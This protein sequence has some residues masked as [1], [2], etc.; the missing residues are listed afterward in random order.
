MDIRSDISLPDGLRGMRRRMQW[1]GCWRHSGQLW[2]GLTPGWILFAA[3]ALLLIPVLYYSLDTPYA[4]VDDFAVWHAVRT[5][6]GPK[7]FYQSLVHE[8][9][10]E[11]ARY[12]PVATYYA[13]FT[14]KVYGET[15]WLHHLTRW[16]LHFGAVFVWSA[17]FLRFCPGRRSAAICLVPMGLLVW[18]WM[19]YPNSPASRLA[20]LELYTVFFLGVCVWLTALTLQ[21]EWQGK[22]GT[23]PAWWQYGLLYAA[24]L[25]L[26]SSKEIDIA[27]MLWILI[28]Y[29]ALAARRPSLRAVLGLLPLSLIF[30]GTLLRVYEAYSHGDYGV[31]TITKDL[32]VSNAGWLL[33]ELFQA[34]ASPFIAVALALLLTIL[35]AVVVRQATRRRVDAQW[36]FI[37]FLLGLFAAMC[38]ILLTAHLQVLRYWYILIPVF[39]TLLAFG[40][41]F[42]LEAA[43]RRLP[44]QGAVRYAAPAVLA[45]FI[46]LFIG[47]NYY[48]FLW[49]TI[50]QHS[51]RQAEARTIAAIAD[52]HDA[53][54]YIHIMEYED[55]H[56]YGLSMHFTHFAPYWRGKEYRIHRNPPDDGRP[57]YAVSWSYAN[58][59]ARAQYGPPAA[60]IYARL[61]Y[62]ALRWAYIAAA[63]LQ[64]GAPY[65]I[66]D[67]GAA[68]PAGYGWLLHRLGGETEH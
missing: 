54:E 65:R 35:L 27:A 44:V 3:P 2:R 39:T 57:Y 41:R 62:P 59:P 18:L 16:L 5:L 36:V 49:Q 8:F 6:D 37:V 55:E 47:S 9:S 23:G 22:T 15:M 63:V 64:G 21:R 66:N 14:W 26:G 17:A 19:F 43:E 28:F 45:G 60:W 46:A 32:I 61:D 25:G 30:V 24:Y 38:C 50:S 68:S 33:I 40:A 42:I 20:P 53:G 29:G 13:A 52:L 10:G 1:P 51:V 11:N 7:E 48:H 34:R 12:R 58:I 67:H 56:I 4:F 31:A